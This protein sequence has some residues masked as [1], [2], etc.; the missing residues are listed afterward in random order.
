MQDVSV[1]MTTVRLAAS[2]DEMAFAQLVA[3]HNAPMARVAYFIAGD[4]ETAREAVQAAWAI[5]WHR[6]GGLCDPGRIGPWL[7]SITANEARRAVRQQR[8]RTVVEVSALPRGAPAR[9][10]MPFRTPP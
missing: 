1:A 2:G 5:A 10:S 7:V 8:R 6:L 9:S 4:A 3:E